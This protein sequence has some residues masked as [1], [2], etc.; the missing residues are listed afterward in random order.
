MNNSQFAREIAYELEN[1]QGMDVGKIHDQG[2]NIAIDIIGGNNSW[3][4]E[5]YLREVVM[6]AADFLGVRLVFVAF[7]S[8]IFSGRIE[9]VVLEF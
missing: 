7:V 5:D 6:D 3:D 8:D 1:G 4:N 2:R 9:Q